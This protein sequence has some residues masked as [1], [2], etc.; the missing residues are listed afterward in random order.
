MT[1]YI[2]IHPG[3]SIHIKLSIFSIK[4]PICMNAGKSHKIAANE[5]CLD[6]ASLVI[7]D[8]F[9]AANAVG[10]VLSVCTGE[11]ADIVTNAI[12]LMQATTV[13]ELDLSTYEGLPSQLISANV[14]ASGNYIIDIRGAGYGINGGS[15]YHPS[16]GKYIEIRVSM[17]P[18]G[19]I[20]DCLTVSEEETDG[21][22]S[23]C[24]EEAF[25][26]Q[27]DGKTEETY[28]SI[29]AISGATMTTDGYKKAIARAFASIKIFEA[30]K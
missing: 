20:I 26:G 4:I 25:Y 30:D 1:L 11:E 7:G 29:D 3:V 8:R 24:A 21:I 13:A 28:N 12:A 14:T 27:F 18:D 5:K 9:I 10:N 6:S 2:V 17:T 19:T 22:G 23:A 15:E 16:S